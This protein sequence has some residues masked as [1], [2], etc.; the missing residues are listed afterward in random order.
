MENNGGSGNNNNQNMDED[1]DEL[2]YPPDE[3][4]NSRQFSDLS[5]VSPP[6]EAHIPE[7]LKKR[8]R[9]ILVWKK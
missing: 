9:L 7:P 2:F 3:Y 4:M 5:S 1:D 6:P 8:I